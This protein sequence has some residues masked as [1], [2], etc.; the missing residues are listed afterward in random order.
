M[1]WLLS[2]L[3]PAAPLASLHSVICDAVHEASVCIPYYHQHA[4]SALASKSVFKG[5]DCF[6]KVCQYSDILSVI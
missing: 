6:K 2:A 5:F 3:D 4:V 1:H